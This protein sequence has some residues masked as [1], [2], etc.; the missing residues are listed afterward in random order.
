MEYEDASLLCRASLALEPTGDDISLLGDEASLTGGG[1]YPPGDESLLYLTATGHTKESKVK[2]ST[3][4][5]T[6]EF[7]ATLKK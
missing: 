5:L 3:S 4:L 1:V 6:Q 2:Q 7:N